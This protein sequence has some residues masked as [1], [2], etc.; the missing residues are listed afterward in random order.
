MYY[1]NT[2]LNLTFSIIIICL[3]IYLFYYEKKKKKKKKNYKIAICMWYNDTIKDYADISKEINQVVCYRKGYHLIVS[4]TPKL[5]DRH[6][7]WERFPLLLDIMN[8]DIYD[9]VIWI[10][11]DA[12][13]N[14]SSTNS[15]EDIITKYNHKDIIFSGDDKYDINSGVIILKNTDYSKKY[16]LDIINSQN[17]KECSQKF[18]KRLWEQ[19]C[20][21]F[22]YKNNI[23]NIKKNSVIIPYTILQINP[24]NFPLQE[25]YNSIIYHY[26]KN[27]NEVREKE[28]LKIRDLL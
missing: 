16:C 3:A 23:Y 8:K 2:K 28:L 6:P 11:A 5:P 22:K 13:F 4:N 20:V 27:T 17:V 24:L 25:S 7:A 19:D 9:Y 26:S 1:K 10:D 14:P 12:C 21:T 18:H 15:I